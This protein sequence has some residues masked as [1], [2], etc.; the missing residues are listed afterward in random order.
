MA[1]SKLQGLLLVTKI[2]ERL[3]S[4]IP[5]KQFIGIELTVYGGFWRQGDPKMLPNFG[6]CLTSLTILLTVAA[7]K[8]ALRPLSGWFMIVLN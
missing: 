5:S 4:G 1:S 7:D 6:Y 3:L 8:I 2:Q